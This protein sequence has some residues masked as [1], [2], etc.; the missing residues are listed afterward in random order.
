MGQQEPVGKVAG[1][2]RCSIKVGR[3]MVVDGVAG[4]R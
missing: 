4:G 3:Y 1:A 2:A